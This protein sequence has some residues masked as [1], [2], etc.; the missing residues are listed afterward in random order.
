MT[1]LSSQKWVV[2]ALGKL[3][4][5]AG[6][7]SPRD[8]KRA[9]AHRT[10]AFRLKLCNS[11]EVQATAKTISF[12]RMGSHRRIAGLPRPH[13][14]PGT[15]CPSGAGSWR[16]SDHRWIGSGIVGTRSGVGAYRDCLGPRAHSGDGYAKYSED[17]PPRA[18]NRARLCIRASVAVDNTPTIRT[19]S[20]AIAPAN[21]RLR[22]IADHGRL[23]NLMNT[24]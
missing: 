21:K 22:A 9:T 14:S 23:T 17:P 7:R 6:R 2:I 8:T 16:Q 11:P 18:L 10:P 20:E 3:T 15:Q 5:R 4:N 12:L 24:P 13:V 19:C 1:L